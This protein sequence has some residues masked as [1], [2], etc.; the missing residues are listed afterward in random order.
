ME[1]E[2]TFLTI[3]SAIVKLF[4]LMAVGYILRDRKFI[5]NKFTNT[6]SLLLIR[7]FFPALIISKMTTHFSYSEY[8]HWWFLPLCA[9]IFSLSGMALGLGIYRFLKGSGPKREFVCGCG[10]QNCGY[11]P[12][13]LIFFSFAG[14]AGERLLIYVFLFTL[15]FNILM[16]S[17]VPLFLSGK[18][19]PA[20]NPKVF[21]NAP[22]VA[23]LFS[24]IWVGLFGKGSVP[25]L[26]ADPLRQVGQAAFPIM[27][28]ALG[29]YLREYKAYAPGNKNPLVACAFTKL[30]LFPAL[31]LAL[32]VVLPLGPDY[33]FFLFLQAIMPT[34]V[35]L[36]V[37]GS[38]TGADNKFLSSS[39]F[40]THLTAI[41]SIPVWLAVY[42]F[43]L[44]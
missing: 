31:V 33:K 3:S 13:N 42:R 4:I 14:M 8:P 24:L 6:L 23:I 15:G 17:L 40:F 44:P 30:V 12:I 29:A 25:S 22:V 20:V 32:L 41:F 9:V 7:L 28:L 43:L 26:V 27:M 21:L 38:Y 35:S 36:V 2:F 19:K 16:W 37:I 1:I 34:A 18:L 10:F 5:D 39:I 11:L